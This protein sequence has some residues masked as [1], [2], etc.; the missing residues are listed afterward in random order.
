VVWF[1]YSAGRPPGAAIRAAGGE[2]VIRYIGLGS[3]SKQITGPEYL[4]LVAAGVKVLLV[5][6]LDVNDAWGGPYDDD[7]ARGRANAT[8][9]LNAARARGIPDSVG[10]AAA[11]DAHA[12]N[13]QQIT[14]AVAYAQ[15]FADVLGKARTGFYGFFETLNA[16]HAAGVAGWYW[17][18]GAEPQGPDRAWVNLW[19][20]NNG[21]TTTFIQG[22]QCDI[23][24]MLN[25]PPNGVPDVNLT[26]RIPVTNGTTHLNDTTVGD[27]LG[28]I[29]FE[30][31]F[32][33]ESRATINRDPNNTDTLLGR[34]TSADGNAWDNA[35]RLAALAG[36]VDAIKAAV[37]APEPTPA[38]APV[39]LSP[40]DRTAIATELLSLLG[41]ALADQVADKLA[42]R[43]IS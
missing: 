16:V 5:V 37:T 29:L 14:D 2:G 13:A 10:M 19:Q 20:R 7:R 6:E 17:R 26:D 28:R 15:G 27:A 32:P 3:E 21:Q 43:L 9:G 22:V 23:N 31:V 25:P 38:P 40:A 36:S 39:A 34:A 4:D 30:L 33:I 12:A 35:Q 8:I 18:C 24:D 41:P 11:A 1:D 42:T